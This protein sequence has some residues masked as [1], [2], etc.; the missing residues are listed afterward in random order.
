[1]YTRYRCFVGRYNAINYFYSSVKGMNNLN[2]YSHILRSDAFVQSI[3]PMLHWE[4][5]NQLNHLRHIYVETYVS[6]RSN[7]GLDITGVMTSQVSSIETCYYYLVRVLLASTIP[8]RRTKMEC[9]SLFF[10]NDRRQYLHPT[11]VVLKYTLYITIPKK[12]IVI[13]YRIVSSRCW[14]NEPTEWQ[15]SSFKWDM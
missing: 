5:I 9:H 1:M 2:T 13:G 11:H 6:V 12:M 7:N 4:Q 8:V 10:L 15:L 3:R 14:T